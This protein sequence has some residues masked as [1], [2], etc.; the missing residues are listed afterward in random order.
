MPNKE[1]NTEKSLFVARVVVGEKMTECVSFNYKHKSLVKLLR[2]IE[3]SI[4]MDNKGEKF[5]DEEVKKA[6]NQIR[7]SELKRTKK[8]PFYLFNPKEDALIQKQGI[9]V[10]I[11]KY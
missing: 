9:T 7:Y 8:Q 6:N 3:A 2:L 4:F 1:L 5:T 11:S 10:F